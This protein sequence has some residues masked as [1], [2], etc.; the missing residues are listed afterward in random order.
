MRSTKTRTHRALSNSPNFTISITANEILFICG[1]KCYQNRWQKMR[2]AIQIK[3]QESR[4]GKKNDFDAQSPGKGGPVTCSNKTKSRWKNLF[5]QTHRPSG[6]KNVILCFLENMRY[7]RDS[8]CTG[9]KRRRVNSTVYLQV[10]KDTKI[11]RQNVV[12]PLTLFDCQ[13]DKVE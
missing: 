8:I 10:K 12:F 1:G 4:C 7:I 3:I 9:H 11:P 13:A 6:S 5:T 2:Q